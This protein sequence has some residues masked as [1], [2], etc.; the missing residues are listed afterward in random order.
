MSPFAPRKCAAL[1]HFCGAKGDN[2]SGI[3]GQISF[4]EKC[5][6]NRSF[7]LQSLFAFA[8]ILPL[9][10]PVPLQAQM[11]TASSP[12]FR[13]RTDTNAAN[14]LQ[15]LLAELNRASDANGAVNPLGNFLQRNSTP[16]EPTR[17]EIGPTGPDREAQQKPTI[18]P[19]TA[20]QRLSPTSSS[21][22]TS[23]AI[24][25]LPGP[26]YTIIQ[27]ASP[28]L[29]NSTADGFRPARFVSD[30][31]ANARPSLQY[32]VTLAGADLPIV[33]QSNG[34]ITNYQPELPGTGANPG[35][36][37]VLPNSQPVLPT[38]SPNYPGTFPSSSVPLGGSNPLPTYNDPG[39]VMPPI[40]SSPIPSSAPGYSSPPVY[41]APINPNPSMGANPG[42]S[43]VN[44]MRSP[45]DSVMPNAPRSYPIVNS[46]PFV[47]SPPCQFDARYMVSQ[48]AY[49]Q[50]VDPCAQTR[51][52]APNGYAPS[53]Y[54]TQP[55][56]SP[57]SYAP[58]TAMPPT[59]NSGYRPL[60]GFGQSLSNAY[61]GRGIIGQPTA[62]VAGQP[63]RNFLRYLSP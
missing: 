31:E 27:Q 28:Q 51:C 45:S 19:K 62:Y 38:N 40:F 34:V 23:K 20:K 47:S 58:P 33:G 1:T 26:R 61:L 9:W 44:P 43:G 39:S 15:L 54:A 13:P 14:D 57:F 10:T 4:D 2:A 6:M 21:T 60:I 36:S 55:G 48:S 18:D 5:T 42:F 37:P 46:A 24:G 56:G 29:R 3:A 30:I 12:L 8:A 49:R 32:P 35:Y 41:S 22:K 25:V 11:D 63:I 17:L 53:P 59:N 52:G 16:S 50:A 7:R